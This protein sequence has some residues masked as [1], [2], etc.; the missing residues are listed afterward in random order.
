MNP[1]SGAFFLLLSLNSYLTCHYMWYIRVCIY[2]WE[3]EYKKTHTHTNTKQ[4]TSRPTA[5]IFN[6]FYVIHIT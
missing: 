2:T 6:T 5:S 3:G 4:L 1:C